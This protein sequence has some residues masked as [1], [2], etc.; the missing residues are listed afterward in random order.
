[1][2]TGYGKGKGPSTI[3]GDG[4]QESDYSDEK[5]EEKKL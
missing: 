5:C 1:M 3:G 4:D 2:K